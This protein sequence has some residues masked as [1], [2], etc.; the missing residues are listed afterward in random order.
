MIMEISTRLF[1]FP[2]EII[3]DKI[4]DSSM[5]IHVPQ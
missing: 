5:K 3:Y 4:R 2:L 1:L